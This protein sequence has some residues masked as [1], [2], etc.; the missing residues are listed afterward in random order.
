MTA[1]PESLTMQTATAAMTALRQAFVADTAPVWR[2]DA[3]PLRQLDSAAIAVL[4]ECRRIAAAAKRQV[5]IVAPPP[6][7]V[8]LA[9]LYGVETLI[10][11][12]AQP[13]SS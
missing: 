8:E 12:V 10:G 11:A 7:L 5:E 13:H 2:I 1:L 9:G 6:R 4:L 3:A